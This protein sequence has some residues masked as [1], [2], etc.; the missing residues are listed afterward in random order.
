[1]GP[2]GATATTVKYI[3]CPH[4][5]YID[6]HGVDDMFKE[7]ANSWICPACELCSRVYTNA[8]REVK[9]VELGYKREVP[10]DYK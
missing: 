1:M 6:N 2:Y 3:T 8:N 5:G 7:C 4:C 9:R 10:I